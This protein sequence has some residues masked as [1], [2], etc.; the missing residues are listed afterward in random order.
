[1]TAP[2]S[3][4]NPRIQ[5]SEFFFEHLKDGKTIGGNSKGSGENG[6]LTFLVGGNGDSLFHPFLLSEFHEIIQLVMFWIHHQKML[7]SWTGPAQAR[8]EPSRLW[9]DLGLRWAGSGQV[10]MNLVGLGPGMGL[11]NKSQSR[12]TR[13]M[14][15]HIQR[16]CYFISACLPNFIWDP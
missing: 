8:K 2:E 4:Q 1:M 6:I 5:I 12:L 7:F 15:T 14:N 3:K 16:R 11:K 9:A 13:P 10:L